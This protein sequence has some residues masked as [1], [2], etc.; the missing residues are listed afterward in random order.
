MS[1]GQPERLLFDCRAELRFRL[2]HHGK[3]RMQDYPKRNLCPGRPLQTKH[4]RL[5]IG[6]LA[7]GQYEAPRDRR[8]RGRLLQFALRL[9]WPALV[10]GLENARDKKRKKRDAALPSRREKLLVSARAAA[11]PFDDSA[12]VVR[13][14]AFRVEIEGESSVIWLGGVEVVRSKEVDGEKLFN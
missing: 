3:R 7:S 12:R 4:E 9:D 13:I 14:G 1:G 11:E 6:V 5:D 10:Q 8:F 2:H